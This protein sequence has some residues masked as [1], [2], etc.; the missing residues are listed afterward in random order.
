MCWEIAIPAITGILGNVIGGGGEGKPIEQ[1]VIQSPLAKQM[2]Q[3]LG[4]K[5]G[6]GATPMS[7]QMMNMFQQAYQTPG[8]SNR[9]GDIMSM[10]YGGGQPG[11]FGMPQGQGQG[12][13]GGM[14]GQPMQNPPMMFP[15]M[16]GGR[17]PRQ[18]MG[19]TRASG[20]TLP[21]GAKYSPYGM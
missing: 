4:G 13:P 14:G 5:I 8:M 20:Q 2:Q 7:P 18:Q 16:M 9:A 15:S 12:M 1:Q 6:Q 21:P 3:F 11:M 10:F 17:N 19:G